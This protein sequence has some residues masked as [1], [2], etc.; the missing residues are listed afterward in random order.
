MKNQ[1]Y[2]YLRAWG[3]MMGSLPHYIQRQIEKAEQL[4]APQ[5]T[6][7]FVDDIPS[8]YEGIKRADTK[9]LIDNIIADL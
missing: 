4:E 9:E 2:P 6:I 5:T 1:P 8:L 3:R 7:Y